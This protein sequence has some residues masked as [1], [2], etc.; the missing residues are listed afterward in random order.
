MNKKKQAVKE[1]SERTNVRKIIR[2]NAF[3]IFLLFFLVVLLILAENY[4]RPFPIVP[5]S[6]IPSS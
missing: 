2:E 5:G 4:T 3:L 6:G 1:P